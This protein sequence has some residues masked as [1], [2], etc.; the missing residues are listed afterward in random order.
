ME[1]VAAVA[2]TSNR[3]LPCLW[4]VP[5]SAVAVAESAAR[6]GCSGTKVD[7]PAKAAASPAQKPA[8]SMIS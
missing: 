4:S 5:P 3:P 1:A 7:G 6:S 8:G 2:S